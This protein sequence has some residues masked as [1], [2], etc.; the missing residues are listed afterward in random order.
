MVISLVRL[1]TKEI[2]YGNLVYGNL[3]SESILRLRLLLYLVV[4]GLPGMWYVV[5]HILNTM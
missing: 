3:L 4:S 2:T 5:Y 1:D